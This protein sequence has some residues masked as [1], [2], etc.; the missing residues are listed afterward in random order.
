MLQKENL[1]TRYQSTKNWRTGTS[2]IKRV[3]VPLPSLYM[4]I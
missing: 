3:E 1:N 4:E 2:L